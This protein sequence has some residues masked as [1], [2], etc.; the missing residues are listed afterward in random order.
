MLNLKSRLKEL[1]SIPE[2][3]CKL[4]ESVDYRAD[5]HLKLWDIVFAHKLELDARIA[6]LSEQVTALSAELQSLRHEKTKATR[7]R[8]A[9]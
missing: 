1:L 7:R 4:W 6:E 5:Q 8:S 9:T 2:T 3:L